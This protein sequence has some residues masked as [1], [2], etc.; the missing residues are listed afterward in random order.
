VD[1]STGATT[2][3]AVK[4]GL[5]VFDQT[6]APGTCA[7]NVVYGSGLSTSNKYTYAAAN[8]VGVSTSI[9]KNCTTDW[10]MGKTIHAEL[11]I[12]ADG[13]NRN[14]GIVLNYIRGYAAL[15]TQ[16]TYLAAVIDCNRGEL[17]LLRFNGSR[18]VTEHSENFQAV[19]NKW[20]HLS[21]RPVAAGSNVAVT[22]RAEAA[23]GSVTPVEFSV[24]VAQYGAHIGQAGFFAN[25]AYT[26]FNKFKIEN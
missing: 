13:L 25:R 2:S 26:Y 7:S 11:K 19:I 21:V 20:Y 1:F 10:A 3:F 14:G 15:N 23:D 4:D 5:F 12:T 18:F 9:F 8:V 16:T 6:M 22:V 24:S 17:R